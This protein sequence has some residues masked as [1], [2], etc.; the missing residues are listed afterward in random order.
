[1]KWRGSRAPTWLHAGGQQPSSPETVQAPSA[2]ADMCRAASP[3]LVKARTGHPCP[4]ALGELSVSGR[5]E[6]VSPMAADRLYLLCL[7][8]LFS[9]P[10][11]TS[12]AGLPAAEHTCPPA[13]PSDPASPLRN[14]H[15]PL[16]IVR[17]AN[18]RARPQGPA[19]SGPS[20]LS[21]STLP[22]GLPMAFKAGCHSLPAIFPQDTFLP[23]PWTH[24]LPFLP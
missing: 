20:D 22:L 12:R 10:G 13:R 18:S 2:Q 7:L 3:S 1:M 24:H 11:P 21:P 16:S 4:P 17:T 9:S 23:C 15:H 19:G 5:E 14:P 8:F 6:R